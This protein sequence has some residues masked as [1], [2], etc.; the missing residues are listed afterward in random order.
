MKRI[1]TLTIIIF[2][3]T[4]AAMAQTTPIKIDNSGM[5]TEFYQNNLKLNFQQLEQAVKTN[6]E[7][8]EKVKAAKGNNILASII[9]IPGGFLIGY[10]L[11]QAMAG[12]EPN[13]LMAGIGAGLVL[14]SIPISLAAKKRAI[15]GVEIYN[16]SLNDVSYKNDTNKPEFSFGTTSEGVG[17]RMRF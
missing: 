12:G 17:V 8:L 7:A 13:W 15:E 5:G 2:S 10:P 6:P 3:I 14:V 16:S 4:I 9:S 11:G 1:I